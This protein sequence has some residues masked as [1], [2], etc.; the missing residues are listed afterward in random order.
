MTRLRLYTIYLEEL[1]LRSVETA[2]Q[3]SSDDVR[4]FKVTTASGRSRLKA[5]LEDSTCRRQVKQHV[6][7][8]VKEIDNVQLGIVNQAELK[9]FPRVLL[10]V[11]YSAHTLEVNETSQSSKDLKS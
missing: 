6:S 3:T 10:F 5:A 4:I 8:F 9:L 1:F 11:L 7:T 2:S